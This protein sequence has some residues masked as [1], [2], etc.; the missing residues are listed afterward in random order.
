MLPFTMAGTT[1]HD[2]LRLTM[3][4]G[5]GPVLINRLLHQLGSAAA[6][7]Q[8]PA[9]ELSRVRGISPERARSMAG[10]MAGTEALAARELEEAHRLGV[11]IISGFDDEYP[12]LL[13]EI[14]DPPAVLAVRG[15]IEPGGA[16]RYPVA[17]VGSRSCSSYGKEQAGRFAGALAERGLTVVSG[18]ARGIDTAAHHGALRV[19]GRTVAVLGCGLAHAYP[20]ENAELFD[21]IADGGG[22]VVSELPMHTAPSAENF[23]ARNRI[24]SGMSLGVVVIEAG[25]RSGA[26]ITARLAGE[27]HGREVFAVPGRIDSVASEGTLDLLK[28][29]GAALVTGAADVVEALESRA[30]HVFSGSHA[31]VTMNPA[32]EAASLFHEAATKTGA[33]GVLSD[34]QRTI[35]EALDTPRTMDELIRATGLDAGRVMSELTVL[36]IRRHVKRAGT[37]LERAR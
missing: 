32:G 26:L 25:R 33:V 30:R 1:T 37:R 6:A 35:L 34:G 10:L 18:G 15:R 2:L 3:V 28:Q 7:L 4:P 11:R 36:E 16:D 29:G 20:G 5:L 21:R 17:I 27:E 24:I 14:A 22:A 13:K 19:K 12:A 31:A 23:P 8:A 9:G